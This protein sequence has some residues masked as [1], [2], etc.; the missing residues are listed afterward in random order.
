M[1]EEPATASAQADEAQKRTAG[2]AIAS[3][4]QRRLSVCLLAHLAPS[5]LHCLSILQCTR[6]FSAAA[7]V[8]KDFNGAWNTTKS[9]YIG[10]GERTTSRD[11]GDSAAAAPHAIAVSGPSQP[12]HGATTRDTKRV[13]MTDDARFE[14]RSI[15]PNVQRRSLWFQPQ[16]PVGRGD[17]ALTRPS[18]PALRGAWRAVSAS[19]VR[20]TARTFEN[21]S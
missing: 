14:W 6:S 2:A 19:G 16:W 8:P 15:T 1:E 18:P 5:L 13:S 17:V 20:S 10:Y 4:A 11:S 7:A 21:K 12:H 3:V 9:D